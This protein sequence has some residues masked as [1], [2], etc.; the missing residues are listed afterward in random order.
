MF[1]IFE[2][3]K[4]TGDFII[5]SPRGEVRDVMAR[6]V[7][8]APTTGTLRKNVAPPHRASLKMVEIF[9]LDHLLSCPILRAL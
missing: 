7:S 5:T 2:H 4:H 1:H 3:H 8:L 6:N 9:P